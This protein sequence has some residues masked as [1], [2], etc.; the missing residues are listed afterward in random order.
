MRFERHTNG[1]MRIFTDQL[2]SHI[3]KAARR[4]NIPIIWW[5]SVKGGKNGDKNGDKLR[6]VEK[7]FAERLKKKNNFVY[8]IIADTEP[9]FSYATRELTDKKGKPYDK[10]YK[11]RKIVKHY[12]IYF[13]DRLLGGPCYLKLSTYFPFYAEFYF[14]GHNMIK[15]AMDRKG[16]AY[17][18][19]ENAFTMIE[20]EKAVQKIAWSLSGKQVQERID[21]W[22]DR[23]FRFDKGTYSTRPAAL[24]HDWYC[25][26]VEVSTNIIFKSARFCTRL[27]ERLLDKYT[28]IGSPDSLSQIFGKRRTRKNTK[29]TRRLYDNKAC[30]KYWFIRNSIKFYNKLGYFLRLETTINNP[31]SLGLNK[32]VIHLREYLSYG[33]K[34]NRRLMTCFADVDVSS[35]AENEMDTLNKPVKTAKGQTV[36]AP[37]LRKKRQVA[38]FC[39]LLNPKYAVHG[40][41]TR[42]L[43]KNLG[44]NFR[45]LSQIR[46]ELGKLKERGLVEKQQ[47]QS[48][49]RVTETRHKI[50]WAKNAWNL[51]F[52]TPMISAIYKKSAGQVLSQPSKLE[53]AYRQLD[54]GLSLIAQELCLKPAA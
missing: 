13:N 8:C 15:L 33:E 44:E 39:E 47:H 45:N 9:T 20:N 4:H 17:R 41:R 31:K 18:K 2:N 5:P 26:Q 28:R 34:C 7:K 40:F 27:F 19:D 32:P 54:D 42:D 52:E 51:Y 14:N 12:Y 23:F 50:L 30:M 22:M 11:C 38:L 25:S 29:S 35:I 53:S 37:D 21:Y 43:L 46:Y 6:Y 1:V 24:S 36:S 3:E 49:Y 16:L 10:M 48:F